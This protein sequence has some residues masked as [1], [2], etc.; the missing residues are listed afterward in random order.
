MNVQHFTGRNMRAALASVREAL[1][2]DALILETKETDDGFEVSAVAEY[3][4][5]ELAASLAPKQQPAIE[6]AKLHQ[7]AGPN[8]GT[9]QAIMAAAEKL[10]RAN[11]VG[12]VRAEM[13]SIRSLVESHLARVGWSEIELGSPAKANVMRNLSALGLAPDVVKTL[14]DRIDVTQTTGQAW[15]APMQALM[16]A[17]PFDSS[18]SPVATGIV[19]IVGPSGAGHRHTR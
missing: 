3:D 19:A 10:A 14:V 7:V 9:E 18:L 12:A 2:D 11:D 4:P 17:L 6:S 1:G 15:A 16:N 5:E 8:T 13:Q